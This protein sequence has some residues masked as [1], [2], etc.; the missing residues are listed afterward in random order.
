MVNCNLKNKPS[1][2]HSKKHQGQVKK[3]WCI[4]SAGVV[5]GASVALAVVYRKQL[6]NTAETYLPV[7]KKAGEEKA[8]EL[9]KLSKK[10]SKKA[11]KELNKLTK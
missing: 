9:L 7:V 2:K 1:C 8:A 3:Q 11:N 4:L 6:G 5:I 10:L